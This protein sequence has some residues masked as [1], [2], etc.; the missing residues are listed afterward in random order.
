VSDE[1][2][3]IPKYSPTGRLLSAK[4]FLQDPR[5]DEKTDGAPLLGDFDFSPIE[6]RFLA[7]TDDVHLHRFSKKKAE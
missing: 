1:K 3:N 5:H 2:N 6:I 4:P 7:W